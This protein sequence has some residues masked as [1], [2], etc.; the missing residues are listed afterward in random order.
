MNDSGCA[1]VQSPRH[2]TPRAASSSAYADVCDGPPHDANALISVAT[3]MASAFAATSSSAAPLA[4]I[5]TSFT[6]RP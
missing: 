5:G 1:I 6:L 2:M 4:L 3:L